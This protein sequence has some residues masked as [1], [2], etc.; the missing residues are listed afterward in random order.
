LKF[1]TASSLSVVESCRPTRVRYPPDQSG[2][3]PAATPHVGC[4]WL[5]HP[6]P[7]SGSRQPGART[8]QRSD[9]H[10]RAGLGACRIQ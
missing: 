7:L 6:H 1:A 5:R 8:S 4:I 3:A 10:W 2:S 9:C